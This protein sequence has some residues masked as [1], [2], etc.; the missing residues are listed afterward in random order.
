[1]DHGKI[2]LREWGEL[3]N[4]SEGINMVTQMNECGAQGTFGKGGRFFNAYFAGGVANNLIGKW[5]M[6]GE[7]GIINVQL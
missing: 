7:D 1:M 2:T 6:G 4:H 5:S 3:T